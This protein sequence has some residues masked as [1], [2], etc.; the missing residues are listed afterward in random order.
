MITNRFLEAIET[1]PGVPVG[2]YTQ[3]SEWLFTQRGESED[4]ESV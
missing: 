2:A 1:Q 4:G 3:T